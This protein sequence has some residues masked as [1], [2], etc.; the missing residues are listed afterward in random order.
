MVG[1]YVRLTYSYL[2]IVKV[3]RFNKRKKMHHMEKAANAGEALHMTTVGN[4]KAP[5]AT[6]TRTQPTLETEYV[7]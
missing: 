6:T 2:S 5:A 3:W 4:K 1:K 7:P